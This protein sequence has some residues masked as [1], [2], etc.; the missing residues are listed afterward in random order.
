[1]KPRK[2]CPSE[3]AAT[4]NT[5]EALEI[6]LPRVTLSRTGAE[7]PADM[8]REEWLAAGLRLNALAGALAWLL[9]DWF[10]A[11]RRFL[12]PDVVGFADEAQSAA[13]VA[14]M[15]GWTGG[16]IRTYAWVCRHVPASRRLDAL[17]F[18][19]HAEV[20]ALE[21]DQAD[22]WLARAKA[23]D[24][25]VADLRAAIGGRDTTG[26]P[27]VRLP[28][29]R[30]IMDAVRWFRLEQQAK[31]IEQWEPER[32]AALKRELQPLVEFASRL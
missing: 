20:A 2:K 5:P 6:V 24:W 28:I 19:H 1:M 4:G 23:E 11:G 29:A 27:A 30:S 7:F 14:A 18:G 13:A 31:P 3:T 17:T 16:T 12:P 26:T 21:P 8:T 25:S 9:G 32:R 10:N 15:A 22:E